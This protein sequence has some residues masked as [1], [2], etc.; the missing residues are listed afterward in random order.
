[1]AGGSERQGPRERLAGSP[2]L[3]YGN[4]Q[5]HGFPKCDSLPNGDGDTDPFGYAQGK[6]YGEPNENVDADQDT[7][8]CRHAHADRQPYGASDRYSRTDRCCDTDPDAGGDRCQR[9]GHK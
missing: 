5:R 6:L 2:G 3:A 4:A 1:V 7:D 8:R 9:I